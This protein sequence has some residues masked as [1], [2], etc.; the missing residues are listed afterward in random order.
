M[1]DNKLELII[2]AQNKASKV[3]S[4]IAKDVS[5]MSTKAV[6]KIKATGKAF[7]ALDK[8]IKQ[9]NATVRTS[10]TLFTKL[11]GVLSAGAIAYAI[12]RIG[13]ASIATASDLEEVGSKFDTVFADQANVADADS[14]GPCSG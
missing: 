6:P 13:E 7:D 8:D 1:S 12:K 4:Q 10:S 2:S 9:T 3:L 14:P 11:A 5:G